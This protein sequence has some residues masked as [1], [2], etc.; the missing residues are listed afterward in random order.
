MKPTMAVVY[1]VNDDLFSSF[2]SKLNLY[3]SCFVFCNPKLGNG[4]VVN[5]LELPTLRSILEPGIVFLYSLLPLSLSSLM[6]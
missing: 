1:L 5:Y 4:S 2:T 3:L 6:Y